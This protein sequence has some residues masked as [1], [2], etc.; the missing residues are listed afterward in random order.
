MAALR[1]LLSNSRSSLSGK[2]PIPTTLTTRNLS[3]LAIQPR[4]VQVLSA[5]NA[6]PIVSTS[7]VENVFL[8]GYATT[9]TKKGA[10]STR[11][12]T[13]KKKTAT[14]K[15]A[16]AKKATKKAKKKTVAKKKPVKKRK[17]AAKPKKPA[18]PDVIK[19]PSS[20][21]ISGYIVF[22]QT[23]LKSIPGPG[24][25]GRLTDAVKEWKAL[26]D[27]EKQVNIALITQRTDRF[28]RL[29]TLVRNQL[30][31]LVNRST[32]I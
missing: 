20:R 31:H 26:S 32:I 15:K 10:T 27:T 1:R 29:G 18:R 12:T 9:T 2:V 14:K 30:M 28:I 11:K 21:G 4:V 16:P 17:V 25:A 5:S 6:I 23:Q 19:L 7:T 22:L 3:H 13:A 24:A 8:R